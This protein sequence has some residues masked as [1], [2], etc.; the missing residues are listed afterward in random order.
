MILKNLTRM[1][2]LALGTSTLAYCRR[3]R[4]GPVYL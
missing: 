4:G 2:I 1:A 3:R